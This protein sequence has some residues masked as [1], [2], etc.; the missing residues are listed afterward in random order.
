[1]CYWIDESLTHQLQITFREP[2][3]RDLLEDTCQE[4]PTASWAC[5]WAYSSGSIV[6]LSYLYERLSGR[7][8]L[9]M[10]SSLLKEYYV[11]RLMVAEEFWI[12]I[13]M[14]CYQIIYQKSCLPPFASWYQFWWH[15]ATSRQDPSASWAWN[16][17]QLTSLPTHQD[18]AALIKRKRTWDWTI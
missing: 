9:T 6:E 4:V 5:L 14:V 8:H 10:A 2:L 15:L 3:K 16:C 18:F 11:I 13:G 1:M 12:R 7:I 17:R